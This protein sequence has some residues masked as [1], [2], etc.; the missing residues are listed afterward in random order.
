MYQRV[1]TISEAIRRVIERQG[2]DPGRVRCVLSALDPAP[3]Q[4]PC[5]RDAF[6]Q[7]FGLAAEDLVVGMAAQFIPR[8]GHD[9]LLQAIPAILTDHP[10]TRFLLFGQG[11]L[12]S[13]VS[14]RVEEAGLSATVLLPGFRN[15]L[16]T[17][18]PCLDLLVHPATQEGLGVILLQ[19]GASGIPVVA[20][21]AGGIP[22]VVVH[23]ETGLIVP[24]G[25]ANGPVLRRIVPSG[26]PGPGP[27]TG[28]GGKTASSKGVLRRPHGRR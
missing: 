13:V 4:E 16:P 3:F 24:P 27:R 5:N 20:S 8:K 28:R 11:P 23:E 18:L 9:V 17:L 22:E 14:R 7:A 2:V 10:R 21:Q 15:D 26:R 1:I 12:R 19:A 6:R 25:N